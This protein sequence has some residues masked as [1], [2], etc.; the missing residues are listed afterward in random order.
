MHVQWLELQKVDSPDETPNE[1]KKLSDNRW[2]AQIQ[3]CDAVKKRLSTLV[4]LLRQM[5][6]EDNREKAQSILVNKHGRRYLVHD[7]TCATSLYYA[8]PKVYRLC[9]KL[10]LKIDMGMGIAVIPR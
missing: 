9:A 7:K 6:D 1:L 4:K 10:P 3:A 2:A 5:S 8:S